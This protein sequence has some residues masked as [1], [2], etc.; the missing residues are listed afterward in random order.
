MNQG[1]NWLLRCLLGMQ[2][3]TTSA[4]RRATRFSRRAMPQAKTMLRMSCSP[5]ARGKKQTHFSVHRRQNNILRRLNALCQVVFGLIFTHV[6][7]LLTSGGPP[8]P[9]RGSITSAARVARNIPASRVARSVTRLPTRVALRP[10]D[11]GT[12]INAL[13]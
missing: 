2:I 7:R 11:A 6:S 1:V 8:D 13:V 4:G 10:T 3:C 5:E 9:L 12:L